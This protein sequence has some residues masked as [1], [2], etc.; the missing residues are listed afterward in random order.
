MSVSVPLC[1]PDPAPCLGAG[2]G[3]KDAPC[4]RPS[5]AGGSLLSRAAPADRQADH[6]GLAHVALPHH[7]HLLSRCHD[8]S[9]PDWGGVSNL[10]GPKSQKSF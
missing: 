7:L 4:S 1:G 2:V 3:G 10:R 9:V 5:R 8:S 6:I